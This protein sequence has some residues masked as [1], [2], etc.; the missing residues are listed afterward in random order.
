MGVGIRYRTPIGPLRVDVG[1]RL[2]TDWSADV[3]R[4][5]RFPPVPANPGEPL[6]HREPIAALHLVIGESF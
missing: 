3:P 2:P 1:V 5:E 4:D 6:T